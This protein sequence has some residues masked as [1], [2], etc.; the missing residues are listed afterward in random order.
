MRL[1]SYEATSIHLLTLAACAIFQERIYHCCLEVLCE[2][3][4]SL[5]EFKKVT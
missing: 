4:L 1:I 2:L 5:Y 3:L